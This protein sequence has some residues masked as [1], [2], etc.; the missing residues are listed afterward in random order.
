MAGGLPITRVYRP[1]ST[2]PTSP[3]V[4]T[5]GVSAFEEALDRERM[6][7]ARIRADASE[8]YHRYQ[9]E[10]EPEHD[11]AEE[12]QLI[13]PQQQEAQE[14]TQA[15]PEAT[16]SQ[17]TT[18]SASAVIIA[19]WER[20]IE[21]WARIRAD[22]A[23]RYREYQDERKREQ[24][25]AE[26]EL[27]IS[28]QQQEAHENTQAEPAATRTLA[29]TAS[30][31]AQI[32]A[33][34]ELEIKESAQVRAQVRERYQKSQLERERGRRAGRGEHLSILRQ[35]QGPRSSSKLRMIHNWLNGNQLWRA[36]SASE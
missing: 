8:R 21:I 24:D 28:H 15:E 34:W 25:L 6:F 20:E 2:L 33:G 14:S 4:S 12:E 23:E 36:I 26:R 18:A 7:W 29:P 5:R 22:A 16:C 3:P 17:A 35:Q 19:E 31:S 13:L 11:Q 10:R 9:D 27:L 32:I 30:V 1:A